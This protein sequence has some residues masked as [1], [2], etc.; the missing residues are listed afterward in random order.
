[1]NFA[2]QRPKGLEDWQSTVP[3]ETVERAKK[4]LKEHQGSFCSTANF[5]G[6]G[7]SDAKHELWDGGSCHVNMRRVGV[8]CRDV[9]ATENGRFR[10]YAR[11]DYNLTAEQARPFL[12]WFLYESPYGFIILNRDDL[13]SCEEYG[14]VLAG[15]APTTLVQAACI[16]SRHFYEVRTIAFTTFNQMIER[17]IDGFIAYQICFNSVISCLDPKLTLESANFGVQSIHRVTASLVP[18]QMLNYY[19]GEVQNPLG[20]TYKEAPSIYGSSDL[21]VKKDKLDPYSVKHLLYKFRTNNSDFHNFMLEKE[22][23]LDKSA[24]YRPPNPFAPKPKGIDEHTFTCQQAVTD[25]ADYCQQYI[26]EKLSG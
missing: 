13:E 9:L 1:M 21:F 7:D 8:A 2:M 15:D 23:K 14:F 3:P 17:G 19:R 6:V 24:V 22:G 10:R 20:T 4:L 5:I 16:V 25:V 26:T 18:D 11:A 12:K